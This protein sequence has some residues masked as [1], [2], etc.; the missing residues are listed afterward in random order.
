[1]IILRKVMFKKYFLIAIFMLET[2]ASDSPSL[3][4]TP[5]PSYFFEPVTCT[6]YSISGIPAQQGICTFTA[7]A[8]VVLTIADC[9][10]TYCVPG[11][12][13]QYI[14]LHDANMVQVAY[15]D[16]SCNL[17]SS[18]TYTTTGSCQLYT[19]YQ[20]CAFIFSACQGAFKITGVPVSPTATPTTTIPSANP[21]HIPTIIP[22]YKP[23][24]VPSSQPS[25]QPSTNPT[26][27]PSYKAETWG[28][29]TADGKRRRRMGGLCENHCSH[30]GTCE[31]NNNCKCFVGL[32]GEDEWTG[33]DCSLRTCPKDFA[34]VGDVVNANGT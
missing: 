18:I 31:M 29:V 6:P 28:E 27:A 14:H 4:P 24:H 32:D 21:T 25:S 10:P 16:N 17:C 30:H 33:P 12:N 11:S 26:S 23:T 19:L 7:C 5:S 15:N 13:D 22:T 1:M 8:G 20:E 3:F 2:L 9:D 34:W